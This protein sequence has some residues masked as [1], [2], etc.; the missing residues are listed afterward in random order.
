MANGPRTHQKAS[1]SLAALRKW[2]TERQKLDDW[3]NYRQPTGSG[4]NKTKIAAE[5]KFLRRAFGQNPALEEEFESILAEAQ[6]TKATDEA[7]SARQSQATSADKQEIKRL[8]EEVAVLT[9]EIFSLKQRL[10]TLSHIDE[11]LQST[12]RLVK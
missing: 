11:V 7:S 4:L 12:G 5:C 6:I 10:R 2:R 1:D 3:N 9:A 8:S